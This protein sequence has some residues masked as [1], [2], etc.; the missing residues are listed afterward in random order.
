MKEKNG[1]RGLSIKLKLTLWFTGFMTLTAAV[2]LGLILML[3]GR[4]ERNEAFQILSFTVRGNLQEI[5]LSEGR[6]KLSPE[7]QFYTNDVYLLIYNRSK[8]LLS[9]QA[10]PS[11]PIETELE[12]GV[13]K[14]VSGGKDDFY[15]LD[16][17]IP[18][19]WEDG[20]WL[21]GVLRSP[22]SQR[23]LGSIFTIFVM[24]LPFIILSAALG[25]YL[26]ARRTLDPISRI[27]EAAGTISEGRDLTCRIGLPPGRDEVSRLANAFD[28]MFERLEQSFEAEKQ[29]TSDASHELRTPT[30]VILAQ[31]S[32]AKRHADSAEEYREA[33]EVIE[34]QA[35]RMSSLIEHLLDMTRLEQGTQ[36]LHLERLDLSEMV[37]VLCEEQDTGSRGISISAE[38]AEGIVIHADP[39]LISRVI[40]NLLDNARKYGKEGGHIILRLFPASNM[41]IGPDADQANPSDEA[42]CLNAASD[43]GKLAV[44]QVEDDG[45]GIEPEELDKIW[46]R[47]YQ[48]SASRQCNSGLGLGLSMVRQI[49]RLHGGEVK[50]ASTFGQGSCFTVI[51]PAVP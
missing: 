46:Q 25:G 5:S 36:R 34:R 13:T 22:D 8:A 15:I 7:F 42:I 37:R 27:T 1:N 43:C 6:L 12:N 24:I 50:A 49:V 41:G 31:C 51:L 14:F 3:S 9:G 11:F 26:I 40:L 20:V 19:G 10:P 38:A 47:F 30:T 29:F 48:V 44:L 16:F 45:I 35:R 28:H 33:I 32:Y 2:C 39:F 17:W 4:V 23:T 18:S 21:R